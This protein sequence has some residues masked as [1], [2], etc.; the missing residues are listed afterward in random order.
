MQGMS[1]TLALSLADRMPA[2]TPGYYAPTVAYIRL[3]ARLVALFAHIL[4]DLCITEAEC[5]TGAPDIQP[6]LDAW[7][8]IAAEFDRWKLDMKGASSKSADT[9][10]ADL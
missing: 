7:W 4:H 2:G 3:E 5:H 6:L 1:P 9:S 8:P 10:Y